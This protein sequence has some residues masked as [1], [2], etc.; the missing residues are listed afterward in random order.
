MT[1]KRYKID[2]TYN[3]GYRM[4]GDSLDKEESLWRVADIRYPLGRLANL[5][6]KMRQQWLV[7]L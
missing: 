2:D 6:Y 3:R 4:L 1:Q 5:D 7:P